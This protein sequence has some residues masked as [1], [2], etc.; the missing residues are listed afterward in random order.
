M[1]TSSTVKVG[2]TIVGYILGAA[3]GVTGI[4]VGVM[5]GEPGFVVI[6]IA[7]LAAVAVAF[8]AGATATPQASLPP[9][10]K[11]GGKF[12]PPDWAWYIAAGILVV[13]VVVGAILLAT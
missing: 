9:K 11:Y 13:G 5:Q 8:I 12:T 7:F 3:A 6:G 1:N 4:V 10:V 2:M